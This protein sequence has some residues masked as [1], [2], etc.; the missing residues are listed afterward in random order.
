[1]K[2]LLSLLGAS[3][4]LILI[5]VPVQGQSNPQHVTVGGK[6]VSLRLGFTAQPRLTYAYEPSAGGDIERLGFG[7]RRFRFK[8]Y[9]NYG[10]D[11]R[12]FSQWEGSGPTVALLDIRGEYRLN[13]KTWLRFG[14]FVGAHPRVMAITL[15]S[16]ID[17]IDR[18]GI[19]AVWAR[20]T[21][22]AD[23]RDYGAE[24]LYR[25]PRLEYRLFFA[26]GYNQN[27]FRNEANNASITGGVSDM[28]MAISTMV[29]Y[30]PERFTNSEAGGYVG[31]NQSKNP[32][33]VSSRAPGVGRGFFSTSAHAYWGAIAG[34][35]P[36]RA[37]LDVVSVRY[38]SVAT[39]NQGNYQQTFLGGAATF[40]WLVR[41]A[42]ELDV[43]L[44]NY[45][46]DTGN[47]ASETRLL[48]MG[49]TYSFS[50]ARGDSFMGQKITLG[51]TLKD[52]RGVDDFGHLLILQFQILF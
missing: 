48:T 52:E 22:G 45:N 46:V 50:A 20:N 7:M 2:T 19:A 27:N 37:K 26:N 32:L 16:D 43:I 34:S 28:G 30:F 40:A 15:H 35:Q 18:P 44:E 9:V 17:V 38:E 33:T 13:D 47:A 49:A 39:A 29:R 8:T 24:I 23:A 25:I 14:R 10:E 1:M 31:Y 5:T 11:M 6:D 51:Y 4:F 36:V 41:P 21:I 12:F 42:L 3:L